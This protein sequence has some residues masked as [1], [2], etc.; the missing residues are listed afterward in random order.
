MEN[1]ETLPPRSIESPAGVS[2]LA[3]KKGQAPDG[4][5][6]GART[7][8]RDCVDGTLREPFDKF[9]KFKRALPE[10]LE[11]ASHL[12]VTATCRESMPNEIVIVLKSQQKDVTGT[13]ELVLSVQ[14]F[15][16]HRE[17]MCTY[18]ESTERFPGAVGVIAIICQQADQCG[19]KLCRVV[20]RPT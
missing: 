8:T 18:D 1:R 4:R 11:R 16:D 5:L 9:D 19:V 17:V 13:A 12:P 20:R 2:V 14:T 15:P 7:E 10:A 3:G 6:D